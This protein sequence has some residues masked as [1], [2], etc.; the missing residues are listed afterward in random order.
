[1]ETGNRKD[2]NRLYY[3]CK[4]STAIEHILPR[5]QLLLNLVGKTNDPRENKSFVFAKTY[6]FAGN[7]FL[8]DNPDYDVSQEIRKDCKMLCFSTDYKH[9]FGYEYSRMWALYGDNHKGICIELNK[10]KFIQENPRL[11]F[12]NLFK[13]VKYYEFDISKP[14]KH[15]TID[16]DRIRELGLRDFIRK[17][18]RNEHIDYLFFTKNKEWESEH[19]FRLIYFSDLIENEYCSIQNC[20]ESI[21]LGIDFNE[22]YLPSIL[23]KIPGIKTKILDYKGV[24]LVP[25]KTF[26]E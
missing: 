4:L 10:E 2:T 17:E 18:F 7:Y 22:N 24:R 20:I 12:Q 9:F 6:T 21:F 16:I 8:L 3:Y 19:E 5:K 13:E 26:N 14:L 23:D 25:S 15:I 1:M 11:V